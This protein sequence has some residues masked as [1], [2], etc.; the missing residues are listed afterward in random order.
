MRF[1]SM[2]FGSSLL[3]V[4]GAG[5]ERAVLKQQVRESLQAYRC[6]KSAYRDQVRDLEP[7]LRELAAKIREERQFVRSRKAD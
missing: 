1:A 3:S 6:E 7:K 5:D 2:I 4:A